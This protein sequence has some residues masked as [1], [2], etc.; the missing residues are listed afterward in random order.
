LAESYWQT[1][2]FGKARKLLEESLAVRTKAF[3]RSISET[4][5]SLDLLGS[6]ATSALP[7]PTVGDV[8]Y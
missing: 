2:E 3:G 8:C 1:G 7:N 4:P 6:L 5:A